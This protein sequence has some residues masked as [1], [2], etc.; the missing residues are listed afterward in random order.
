MNAFVHEMRRALR[1]HEI[2]Q[3]YELREGRCGIRQQDGSWGDGCGLSIGF[4]P[5]EIDHILPL[6]HGGNNEFSNLQILCKC[7]HSTKTGKDITAAAKIKR[8]NV[9]HRVPSN[10]KRSRW[11]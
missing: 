11:R 1:P 2:A 7:C 4:K 9:K 5:Y 6:S 3:L 8:K 10:L